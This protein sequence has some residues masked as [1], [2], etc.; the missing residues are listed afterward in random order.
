MAIFSLSFFGII[1][2]LLRINWAVIDSARIPAG[3]RRLSAVF[4]LLIPAVFVPLWAIIQ[5]N[6]VISGEQIQNTYGVLIIDLCLIMPLFII[7]AIL[8]LQGKPI[9]FVLTP[10]L[11][12]LGFTLLF[13]VGF[14]ELI[15]LLFQKPNAQLNLS[16]FLLYDGLSVLFLIIGIVHMR[17]VQFIADEGDKI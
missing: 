17:K 4:T 1:Y 9:G 12:V 16:S 3:I 6:L 2:S 5:A 7:T 8:S 11:F 10:V 15:P 13:P 14:S